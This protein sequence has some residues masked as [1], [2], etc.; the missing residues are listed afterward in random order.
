MEGTVSLKTL[1]RSTLPGRTDLAQSLSGVILAVFTL[2]HLCLVSSVLLSPVI[3]DGLGWMLEESYLAQIFGPL[4]FLLLI[5]HFTL[6]ARKIPFSTEGL[7]V[8]LQHAKEMRHQSTWEWLAQVVSALVVLVFA[9]IHMY[10]VLTTLP[11]TAA[12]SALREQ[13]GWT[14]LY[15][16]LLISVGIHLS[17]GLFR[18]AVK[19]GYVTAENRA[20]WQRR[21]YMLIAAYIII[22]FA[23]MVRFHFMPV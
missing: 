20:V 2:M 12:K 13:G 1:A 23:T 11:I 5:F 6:A 21:T 3:M 19:Y 7:S 22:G 18:V 16:V 4:I 14:P 9:S 17:L 8:Y 10:E 15:I